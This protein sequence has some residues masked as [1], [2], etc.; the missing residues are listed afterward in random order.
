MQINSKYIIAIIFIIIIVIFSL[1][2]NYIIGM[3]EKRAIEKKNSKLECVIYEKT[4]N[5]LTVNPD[6][7]YQIKFGQVTYVKLEKLSQSEID[8]LDSGQRIT[9]TY[10]GVIDDVYPLQIHAT[11]IEVKN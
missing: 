9:V 6:N 2:I 7:D 1:M 10:N 8:K 11:S 5:T 3:G 4:G